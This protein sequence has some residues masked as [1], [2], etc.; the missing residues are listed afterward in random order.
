MKDLCYLGRPIPEIIY[1]DFTT[2]VV[3]DH[4]ANTIVLPEWKGDMEDRALY[5]ILPFLEHLSQ[6]PG[7]VRDEIALYG[8]EDTAYRFHQMQ[9]Q[10]KDLIM[11]QRDSGMTGLI[12][13]LG[14]K[15]Q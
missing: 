3:P 5:D 8:Q 9:M 15:S 12:S 14:K 4:A 11:R 13:N 7:D 1:L 6:K 10:R 2:D